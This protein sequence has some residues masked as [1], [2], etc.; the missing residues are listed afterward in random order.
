MLPEVVKYT[1]KKKLGNVEEGGEGNRGE[2]GERGG[3][4]EREGR[5]RGKGVNP[6]RLSIVASNR[7]LCLA[8][9]K[10]MTGYTNR[11]SI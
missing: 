8:T 10:K 9:R 11:V 2:R 6:T 5:E 7:L 4:E 3:G 1:M